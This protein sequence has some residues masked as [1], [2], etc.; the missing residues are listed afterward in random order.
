MSPV[1][2]TAV[3][4]DEV[5]RGISQRSLATFKKDN[6]IL[7]FAEFI[8]AFF[9]SPYLLSRNA[10]QYFLDMIRH[11]GIDEKTEAEDHMVKKRRFRVFTEQHFRFRPAIVGQDAAQEQICRVLEQ[12]VRQGKIDKLILLHGPNG[13]SKSSTIETLAQ[14]MELYSKT[15]DG[16]IYRFNWI[17]PNEKIET[18]LGTAGTGNTKIGFGADSPRSALAS[19]AHLPED[20]TFCKI[21]SEFKENPIFLLPPEERVDLYRKAFLQR[22][23]REVAEEDIPKSLVTG[24][25]G[26]KS[27]KIFDALSVAYKG[28][29]EKVFKHVQVERFTLSARYRMGIATVEPQMNIDAH[30]RQLTMEKSIQ[31]LPP[32]LQNIRIFEPSGELIDANRGFIEFSDLL[33]RPV[34]AFKYLLTTIEKMQINLASGIATLDMIML[35]SSNEKHLDAF[36][37]SPDW[38]SFKGRI[39][40]VRVPYLLSAQLEE[41]IYQEDARIIE[42]SRRIGPH[43]LSLLAKWAVLT[44]LRQPDPE[45][46]EFSVRGLVSK[47][48]PFEKLSLYDT[49]ELSDKFS[50]DEK[51]SLLK[52]RNQIMRECQSTI[53]YEG[54]FGASPREMKMLL[55]FAS[56]NPQHDSVSAISVFE[57]L[58]KL[59]KER[60]VYDYLQFETRGHYHDVVEFLKFVKRQYGELFHKEFLAALNLFDENQYSQAFS[61]YLNHIVAELKGEKVENSITGKHEDPNQKLMGEVESLLGIEKDKKDARERFVSRIASW[62]VENPEIKFRIEDVFATELNTISSRIYESKKELIQKILDGM[63]TFGSEDYEKLPQDTKSLCEETFRNLETRYGYTKKTTWDSLI[64]LRS[65]G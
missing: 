60:S 13:S 19:F 63:L 9:G 10:A 37:A 27:K 29:L 3:N 11:F 15:P 43:S 5:L 56:Q 59:I 44:R 53:A 41:R 4:P 61:N 16:A 31:N 33:K 47:L 26:S 45:N 14:A 23:G 28:D 64:F 48:D 52:I 51:K 36:K 20:D 49:G 25:L 1:S 6:T 17:F 34:E 30:D 24:A 35:A 7:S 18:D 42:H 58:E 57:E 22:Y 39:E 55:Y 21:V 40:L 32:V 38:P 54:R 12:F 62:K 50:P 8:D 46:Y 2:Q 65:F